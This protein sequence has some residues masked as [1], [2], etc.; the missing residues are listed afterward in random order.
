[1][2]S[3]GD[4]AKGIA[5]ETVGKI[6]KNVGDATDNTRLEAEGT[7]QEVKGKGQQTVGEAK[8]KVKVKDA[9]DRL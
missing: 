2:S 3:M 1:M 9:V 4:K 8:D 5:N 7:A 6:K